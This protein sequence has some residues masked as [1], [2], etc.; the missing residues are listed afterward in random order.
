MSMP[1]ERRA[2]VALL[3]GVALPL[4]IMGMHP[5]GGDITRGGA[6]L[7]L[8][9]H[10]VHGV[11]LAAQPVVFLGLLGLWRSLRSDVAT[12]A[13]VLYGFGIV[14]ILSAATLSGFVAPDVV[15]D[16]VL[17]G[18]TGQLN[19]GFAKVS[20]AAIG[21]SL[22][23]WGAALWPIG[24]RGFAL[25]PAAAGVIIGAVL[26]LGVLTGWLHLTARG[27]VIVTLLQGI[28]ILLVV[29]HLL[30]GGAVGRAP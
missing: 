20:V 13:L 2:A 4:L 23:L 18:Y 24:G 29:W 11:A 1:Q 8:I 19:Q 14:A 17:L 15:T 7:V 6:R 27:I 5:T 26:A 25:L 21:A 16:R 30:R 9:N 10:W 28:W 22:I 12:A 3:I